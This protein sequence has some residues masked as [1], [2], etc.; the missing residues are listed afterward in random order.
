M[1]QMVQRLTREK[2]WDSRQGLRGEAGQGQGLCLARAV[3]ADPS[4]EPGWTGQAGWGGEGEADA[5]LQ[6]GEE[7]STQGR[8]KGE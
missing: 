7:R 4:R 1:Q 2:V 5:R 3:A 6:S 8:A